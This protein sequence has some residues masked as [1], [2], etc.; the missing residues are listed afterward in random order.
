MI[1]KLMGHCLKMSLGI[2][3]LGM[4]YTAVAASETT[5]EKTPEKTAETKK[6]PRQSLD[7]IVAIVND[8]VIT[9]NE[10]DEQVAAIRV[11]ISQRHMAMPPDDVLRKQVL[12]RMIN[13]ELELQMAKKTG[14]VADSHDV[15][16]AID[17][18]AARNHVSVDD[19]RKT[20]EADGMTW[21]EYRRKVKKEVTINQL[22]QKA[23]G[24]IVVTDQQ[25]DDYLKSNT[26][27]FGD[28][29]GNSFHLEDILIPLSVNPTSEE[30]QA[31]KDRA[32]AVMAKVKGGA[33]FNTIA[34][35]ESGGQNA[36]QGGDLG[37]RR[38]P[39]LPEAFAAEVIKMSPGDLAG[40]IRTSN[41][42]H[43]IKLVDIQGGP[44]ASPNK[45]Q[46]RN[47]LYQRKYNEAVENWVRR[48][49]NSAYVK[50]ML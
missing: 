1:Q 35:S 23:V 33:D 6:L 5:S 39:E 18:I 7:S 37:F 31:A 38:L 3:L 36:L 12:E 30:V 11:M 45:D 44:A 43:I 21:R 27:S 40:P 8:N 9:G 47:F 46:V 14:I 20:V 17:E 15:D 24:Q 32:N 50:I 22:L 28:Q 48:I 49:R 25:V 34:A 19:I 16:E 2:G 13:Q 29:M 41:G 10:L 42:W 4:A 26:A